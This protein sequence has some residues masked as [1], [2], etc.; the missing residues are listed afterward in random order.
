MTP[1]TLDKRKGSRFH[2][3]LHRSPRLSAASA[4]KR[5]PLLAGVAWAQSGRISLAERVQRLEQQ[6]QGQSGQ[7]M[8]DALNRI[9][10]LQAE[11]RELRGLI[12]QQ[13]FEIQEGKKRAR[14]QYTDLDS[15]LSRLEGAG[16]AVATG[17]PGASTPPVAGEQPTEAPLSAATESA[18][19]D[20]LAAASAGPGET[21]PAAVAAG[22]PPSE[23]V[24]PTSE[25]ETEQVVYDQAFAALREGRYAESARRFAAFLD[26][27]E[28]AER[29]H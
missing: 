7:S 22:S 9:E 24:A 21:A 26:R 18:E 12:E 27:F 8:V 19:S 11:V 2:R 23:A 17:S 1:S 6:S 3:S 10:A 14:D 15:R 25:G 13:G 20:V 28:R 29:F 16:V 4:G 5:L